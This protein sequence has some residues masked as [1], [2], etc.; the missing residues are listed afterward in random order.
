[1]KV[2]EKLETQFNVQYWFLE[3]GAFYEMMWKKI[4]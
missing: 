4:M 3:N 2:V 1:M